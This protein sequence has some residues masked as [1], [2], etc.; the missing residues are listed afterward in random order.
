VQPS[1]TPSLQF[2]VDPD[3]RYQVALPSDWRPGSQ[4]GTASGPDG[5]F[6]AGDLPEMAFYSRAYQVCMRIAQTLG[7]PA[8]VRLLP[9]FDKVDSCEIVPAQ[10]GQPTWA[11]AVIKAPNQP[12]EKRY[13]S[14]ETDAGHGAAIINSVQML[15][16]TSKDDFIAYPSGPLRPADQAF[17][18]TPR[19]LASGLTLTETRLEARTGD[20]PAKNDQFAAYVPYELWMT[21][22]G[23]KPTAT[24][25]PLLAANQVLSRFGFELRPES[26]AGREPYGL[27][28]NG[29][30]IREQVDFSDAPMLSASGQDFA[31]FISTPNGHEVLRRGGLE[32]WEKF[33]GP[34]VGYRFLGESLLSPFWNSQASIL[35]VRQENQAIYQFATVYG[36]SSG[37]ESFQ[38]WQNHWLM[39]VRAFVIQ[40]GVI[41]NDTLGYEEMY[42]W[43]LFNGKPFYFFRKGPRVGISY[44]GQVQPVYYDEVAHY[45]CCSFAGDNPYSNGALIHFFALREGAWYYVQ[46]GRR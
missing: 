42:G 45:L 29:K 20:S 34:E 44:D 33:Y 43:Q 10:T 3:G 32:Q 4:L 22:W 16:P 7:E 25:D 5:Y 28:Q 30:R 9:Y 19:Q 12:P 39:E 6:K 36:V 8:T 24:P 21:G 27:Y 18:N 23:P 35:E 26:P 40:D 1:S 11:R 15:L 2:Y 46:M 31:L 14:I 41:L 13:F 17:W 38:T 37:L